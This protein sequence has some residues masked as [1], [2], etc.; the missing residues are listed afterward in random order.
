MYIY[1]CIYIYIYIYIY[2]Y[3]YIHIYIYTYVPL[4]P[5]IYAN[6]M[7]SS[8]IWIVKVMLFVST[9]S[10]TKKAVQGSYIMVMMMFT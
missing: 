1:I 3:I 5:M 9:L 2:T 7:V 10:L 4:S 6:R 8:G